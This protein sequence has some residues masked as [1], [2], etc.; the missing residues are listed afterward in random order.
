[1]PGAR[2]SVAILAGLPA[3]AAFAYSPMST[4]AL[5][6]SVAKRA[7]VASWGSVGVSRAITSTPALRAFFTAGTMALVSLGVIRMALAP[8]DIM[9]SMAVTWLALSP[10]NFPAP[11]MSFAPSFF[12]AAWAPSFILT[13]KGLVSVLVMRPT[14]M[15]SAPSAGNAAQSRESFR[16]IFAFI[17]DASAGRRWAEPVRTQPRFRAGRRRSPGATCCRHND[18]AVHYPVGELGRKPLGSVRNL[19][20]IA[21]AG[22]TSMETKEIQMPKTSAYAATAARKPLGPYTIDRRQPGPRDVQIDILFCGVWQVGKQVTKFKPGDLA[23]VGV[24]VDSC[25]ECAPCRSGFE[26]FC[27]KGA[28]FTYNSTEMD[29]KTPTYGGYS[30]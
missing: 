21:Q 24:F 25:R 26:Q 2:S 1:M 22:G 4:P 12:A 13:K 23:G 7:S 9:F 3:M 17:G 16:S 19:W 30:R 15:G 20:R 8:P 14:T 5:K 6:L 11:V 10:S 29:R 27:E 28:A 18:S